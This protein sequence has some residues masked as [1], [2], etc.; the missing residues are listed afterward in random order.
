MTTTRTRPERSTADAL[1]APKQHLRN[2]ARARAEANGPPLDPE[3]VQ[4]YPRPPQVQK[5]PQRIRIIVDGIE[6]VNTFSA[7]R[8]C[9]THHAPTYYIPP[10][11]ILDGVLVPARLRGTFCEYKGRASYYDLKVGGMICPSAAW[12][13]THPCATFA[14]IAGCVAFYA[15]QL[16]AAF[17]GDVR[18]TAQPGGFYGGWVTPNLKGVVKGEKGTEHW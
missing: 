6:I 10:S 18:A 12:T 7:L 13:Y 3:D 16:D 2:G 14:K 11:D 1:A 4:L 17:V 5:V 9:E 8:I 15:N